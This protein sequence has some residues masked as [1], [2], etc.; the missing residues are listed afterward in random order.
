MK[1]LLSLFDYSGHWSQPFEDAGWNVI[2]WDIKLDELMDI[3]LITDA[4]TALDMFDH[5]DGILAG[6]PCTDFAVSGARWFAE[7][8]AD[9]R[10]A[11]SIELVRQVQR[12]ADLYRP[13]DPD[14]DDTFFWVVENPVGRI[15]KLVPELGKGWFFHPYMFAGYVCTHSDLLRLEEIRAKDGEGVTSEEAQFIL[16]CNAYTKYTGLWGEFNTNLLK[17]PVE[18]VK[19]NKWGTPLMRLGGK[20]DRTK[21]IRSNT[22]KGFAQAFF[23]ANKNY[24][25]HQQGQ[26]ILF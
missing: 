25:C 16:E 17:L 2:R 26:Q 6:V 10:T 14:Y 3:N 8:D 5:V 23:D 18:P 1:S 21:E 15:N 19:G 22:P 9:G 4:S 24:R 11:E 12:L 7:K 13:T 20:S